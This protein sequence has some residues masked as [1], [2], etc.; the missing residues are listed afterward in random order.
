MNVSPPH[1]VTMSKLVKNIRT[2]K[3]FFPRVV[4]A[5]TD[6]EREGEWFTNH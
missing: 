4:K 6:K 2:K 1:V 3:F 5:L